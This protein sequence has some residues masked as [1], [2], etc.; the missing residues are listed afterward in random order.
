MLTCQ[1]TRFVDNSSFCN[2]YFVCG[3]A[4]YRTT[5]TNEM[6]ENLF[7]GQPVIL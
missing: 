5:L 3:F 4:K 1:H 6:N 2:E 7:A